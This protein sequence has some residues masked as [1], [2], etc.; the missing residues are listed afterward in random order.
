MQF[1]LPQC[2]Q[3]LFTPASSPPSAEAHQL[4]RILKIPVHK[5]STVRLGGPYFYKPFSLPKKDEQEHQLGEMRQILAPSPALKELQRRLLR[6]YLQYLAVHP[7]ATAFVS[8]SSVAQNARHHAGRA[9]IATVDLQDFFGSIS[10]RRVRAFFLRQ[11]WRGA[12]LGALMRLCVYQNGLPQG[13]PTSPCLSNLVNVELDR[14]LDGLARRSWAA[15]TRYG[16]DITF[17]WNTKR[18]PSYFQASVRRIL[19]AAG[20]QV[21]PRKGWHVYRAAEEPRVAGVVLKKNG[22]LDAT[23]RVHRQVRKLRW[24]AWWRGDKETNARLKGYEGFLRMLK[25]E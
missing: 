4:A 8:G 19:V 22:E 23:N 11:G 5:L 3:N 9:T 1:R 2:I 20:Y 10:A 6:R 7:A 15:Y 12:A 14:A 21:Q 25:S 16:D 13:A 24:R 17:S 18:I